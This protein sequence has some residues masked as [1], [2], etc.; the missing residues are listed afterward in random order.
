MAGEAQYQPLDLSDAQLDSLFEEIPVATPGPVAAKFDKNVA[1][2]IDYLLY[3][4]IKVS[5]KETILR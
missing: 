5:S 3:Q 2:G 4:I 1:V